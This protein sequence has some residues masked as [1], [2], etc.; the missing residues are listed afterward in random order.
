MLIVYD[1][2]VI[3]DMTD[4]SLANMD[5]SPVKFM[6]KVFEANY[7]ESLGVVLVH[8]S[9][10]VFNS[11]WKLIR[12]WLDPVVASKIHFTQNLTEFEQYVPKSHI[13]KELGGDDQW[14][15]QY[16][17]PRSDENNLMD[18]VATRQRLQD[19]RAAVVKEYEQV[20]QQWIREPARDGVIEKR[21]ELMEKLRVGYWQLDPYVRARTL[22]DR[23]GM[24][25]NG[26]IHYYGEQQSTIAASNGIPTA[27]HSAN[28]VD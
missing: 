24:I 21:V 15:Y 12:G 28:D 13:P 2:A 26:K 8:K 7:P 27:V 10:W 11:I 22:Y 6:I 17:E 5:Y 14:E 25:Q 16:I 3:F 9:P 19:E 18:D 4:F 23:T 20:T 1:Q